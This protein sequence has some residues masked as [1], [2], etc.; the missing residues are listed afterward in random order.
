M[1]SS[2]IDETS[3]QTYRRE[4]EP[5]THGRVRKNKSRDA[6]A[7]IEARLAMVNT[8]EGVDLIEQSMEKGLEALREKIQDLHGGCLSHKFNWCHTRSSCPSKTRT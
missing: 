4:I 6:L 8:E 3:K 2:N 5:V 1:S 7:N